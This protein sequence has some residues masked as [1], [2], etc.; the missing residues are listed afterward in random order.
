MNVHTNTYY[1]AKILKHWLI[2]SHGNRQLAVSAYN[3]GHYA[4]T[5]RIAYTCK[6]LIAMYEGR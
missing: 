2:K 4:R 5:R 6:V 1:A 3:R